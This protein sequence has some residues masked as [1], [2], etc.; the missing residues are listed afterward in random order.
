M[1][2]SADYSHFPSPTHWVPDGLPA[3][4]QSTRGTASTGGAP[5]AAQGPQSLTHCLLM[6]QWAM[7][8]K[9]AGWAHSRVNR[10]T[11]YYLHL[12]GYQGLCLFTLNSQDREPQPW[13]T[14][15]WP[16]APPAMEMIRGLPEDLALVAEQEVERSAALLREGCDTWQ[17][18]ARA[19]PGLL[20]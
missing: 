13:P 10:L 15:P 7:G 5:S 9:G 3:R 4:P 12:L 19:P 11:H 20:T 2:L 17:R 6:A 16:P 8:G 1:L 14:W 18:P